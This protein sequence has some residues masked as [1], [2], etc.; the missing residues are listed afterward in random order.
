MPVTESSTKQN[1]DI[2]HT[3]TLQHPLEKLRHE[4]DEFNN[5]HLFHNNVLGF[6]IKCGHE[7]S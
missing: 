5:V 7:T 1:Q 4:S 6:Y 2:R 3:L